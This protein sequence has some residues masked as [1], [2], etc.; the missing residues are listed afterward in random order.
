MHIQYLAI[1]AVEF[2]FVRI[3]SKNV[4][5]RA[6][7]ISETIHTKLCATLPVEDLSR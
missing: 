1:Y 2:I 6:H 4:I 3:Y 7:K 5:T